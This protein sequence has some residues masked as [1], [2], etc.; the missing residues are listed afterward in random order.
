MFKSR[1]AWIGQMIRKEQHPVHRHQVVKEHSRRH[2]FTLHHF[3]I[4][5]QCSKQTSK[6]QRR[7][8]I[9]VRDATTLLNFVEADLAMDVD[10]RGSRD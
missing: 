6:K 3:I 8:T 7:I 1:L 2:I 9:R 4:R 10:G 5:C